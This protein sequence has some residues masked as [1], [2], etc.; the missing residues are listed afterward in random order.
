M[1]GEIDLDVIF[2]AGVP[3]AVFGEGMREQVRT[4]QPAEEK[5]ITVA[6]PMPR[7]APVRSIVRRGALADEVDKTVLSFSVTAGTSGAKTRQALWP[8]HDGLNF[9]DRASLWSTRFAAP[10][11]GIRYGRAGGTPV[12]PELELQG[13][14]A[15]AAPAR[16]ARHVADD[17]PG[18]DL[19]DRLFEG[20]AA[21]Q[22]L[23]LLAGPG[24]DLGLFGRV[25]K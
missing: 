22:R 12:V 3:R 20:K 19:G 17:M 10:R 16:R 5:R 1:V 15:P 21:F 4:R 18:G 6:W 11:G 8:G 24:A 13:R 23:R 25:A 2:G 9:R 7:L 14:D